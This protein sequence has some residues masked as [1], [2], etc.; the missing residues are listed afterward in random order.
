MGQPLPTSG[1]GAGGKEGP[2][3]VEEMLKGIEV[4]AYKEKNLYL[5]GI[6]VPVLGLPLF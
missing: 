5:W 2:A 4:L 1:P 6:E 3:I